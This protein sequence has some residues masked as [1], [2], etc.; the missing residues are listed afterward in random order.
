MSDQRTRHSQRSKKF[1]PLVQNIDQD[2]RLARYQSHIDQL[3]SDYYDSPNKL[4][5][6]EL[7]D[8]FDANAEDDDDRR[9]R[10]K[11]GTTSS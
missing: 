6:D 4:A 11:K 2:I 3:E 5:E 9:G 8:D 7:S 10:K 1:A